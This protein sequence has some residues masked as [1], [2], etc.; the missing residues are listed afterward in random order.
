[1][2]FLSRYTS[3]YARDLLLFFSGVF[4][5]TWGIGGL[6]VFLPTQTEALFGPISLTAPTYFLA[7]Y[8]PSLT[9]LLLSLVRYGRKGAGNLLRTLLPK[10]SNLRYYAIILLGWPVMDSMAL[11]LQSAVEGQPVTTLDFSLWYL[12]PALLLTAVVMDAGPM[13]EELGWRGFALPRLLVLGRSPLFIALS[14]GVVWGIWHLPAFFVA[15]T[16]QHDTSMG[17]LWLLLG[18]TLVSVLMVWLYGRTG[19]DVLAA[20]LLVHLMNNLT[21][22]RLVYVDLVY[23]PFAL[24]AAW[25]LLKSPPRFTHPALPD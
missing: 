24:A 22:A 20:G 23:L 6:Y 5:I 19:G 18:T 10:Q 14:L 8:A 17:I 1:M 9:A 4:T 3:R 12:A 16:A 7:V 13:G 21:Q 2:F 11:V 25:S 15:G